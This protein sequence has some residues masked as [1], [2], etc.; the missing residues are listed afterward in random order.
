MFWRN[1]YFMCWNIRGCSVHNLWICLPPKWFAHPS[2]RSTSCFKNTL[3]VDPQSSNMFTLN[4]ATAWQIIFLKLHW[5]TRRHLAA[6]RLAMLTPKWSTC[7][8]RK[9]TSCFDTVLRHYFN[10]LQL[11]LHKA[12]RIFWQT[13]HLMYWDIRGCLSYTLRLSLLPKQLTQS[14][15]TFTSC[16][17]TSWILLPQSSNMLSQSAFTTGRTIYLHP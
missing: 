6:T 2:R 10:N 14:G 8:G 7:P 9:S 17:S 4:T 13:Y 1:S 5:N 12:G 3:K 16:F 11:L 15:R